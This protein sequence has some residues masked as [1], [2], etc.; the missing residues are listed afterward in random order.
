MLSATSER[1]A[2]TVGF[3]A[4][5]TFAACER[6]AS[7]SGTVGRSHGGGAV[8]MSVS[9]IDATE[10]L[11]PVVGGAHAEGPR[12]GV[13][14]PSP[15]QQQPQQRRVLPLSLA[16][17][18]GA[19]STALRDG[20]RAVAAAQPR[21]PPAPSLDA[22]REGGS[23]GSIFGGSF[24]GS[25]VSWVPLDVD[26]TPMAGFTQS[27]GNDDD[28]DGDGDSDDAAGACDRGGLDLE[29][30]PAARDGTA[31]DFLRTGAAASVPPRLPLSAATELA[32]AAADT[33]AP[34]PSPSFAAAAVAAAAVSSDA[35]IV[36]GLEALLH[37]QHAMHAS[38]EISTSGD[39][40][41][42]AAL[43]LA[44]LSGAATGPSARRAARK[45]AA[46]G[47]SC[48]RCSSGIA[49]RLS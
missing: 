1:V 22:A 47:T 8:S 23:K 33:P 14:A 26:G 9:L 40:A 36:L 39:G 28:G 20:S 6:G 46:A 44:A 21:G 43:P 16:A 34:A 48:R 7:V 30:L 18:V 2:A 11:R 4:A 35:P 12:A 15:P 37:L 49:V 38:V 27:E 3:S 24:G 31:A 19:A 32:P 17:R 42:S 5:A 25:G 29:A 10:W 45:K 41:E 13:G